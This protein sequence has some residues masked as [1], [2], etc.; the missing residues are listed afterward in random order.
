MDENRK[1]IYDERGMIMSENDFILSD[2]EM[3]RAI[4]KY[5]GKATKYVFLSISWFVYRN[6]IRIR[7]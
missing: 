5:A 3:G 4:Q 2:V 7:Y 6:R 1:K